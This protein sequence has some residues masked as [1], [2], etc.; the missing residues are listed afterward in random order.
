MKL[1]IPLLAALLALTGC[2]STGT[3][4][5]GANSNKSQP[6]VVIRPQPQTRPSTTANAEWVILGVSPNGNILHEI[7]KLSIRHKGNLVLFRDRKTIFNPKK[8]NFLST[9]PHKQSINSWEVDCVASTFRLAAM[10]L[11]DE[12]GREILSRTYNDSEIRPMPVV[13]QSASFQQ[14][15]YVCKQALAT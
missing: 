10:Q 6:Q 8:E 12:N 7:D 3:M 14:V 9:P 5:A 2:A 15:D 4:P 11:L 13:R 1:A